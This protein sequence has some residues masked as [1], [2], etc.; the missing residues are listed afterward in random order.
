MTKIEFVIPAAEYFALD[1][2]RLE[3]IEEGDVCEVVLDT[4]EKTAI[5]GWRAGDAQ[6][7]PMWEDDDYEGVVE[8]ILL[9]FGEEATH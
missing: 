8:L 4:R 2:E 5:Y 7:V 1:A 6:S 9:H 3:E